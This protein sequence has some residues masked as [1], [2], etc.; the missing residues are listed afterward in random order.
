MYSIAAV[1]E[2]LIVGD[3]VGEALIVGDGVGETKAPQ[4]VSPELVQLEVSHTTPVKQVLAV[5]SQSTAQLVQ[6]APL[7]PDPV[8]TA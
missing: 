3:V 4:G 5:L 2:A 6:K 7:W 8:Q 1:G